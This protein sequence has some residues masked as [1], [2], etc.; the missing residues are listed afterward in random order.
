MHQANTRLSKLVGRALEG[1][2][3]VSGD[4]RLRRYDVKVL[5]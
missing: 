5:W 2:T 4:A 3:I 1:L